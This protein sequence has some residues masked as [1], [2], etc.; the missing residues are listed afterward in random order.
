MPRKKVIP[1]L[2]T[3]IIGAFAA[4]SILIRFT[5]FLLNSRVEKIILFFIAWLV[6]AVI[7]YL[8]YNKISPLYF[9][10][11]IK[12]KKMAI[13]L[14]LI[15]A[16]TLFVFAYKFVYFPQQTSLVIEPVNE[17]TVDDE[18]KEV[19]LLSI[20][21]VD[22][23]T[24]L[25][26]PISLTEVIYDDPWKT[27]PGGL[28][29]SSHEKA[30]GSIRY[31]EFMNDALQLEFST[32]PTKGLVD[33]TW[34]GSTQ[35]I[36][37][38]SSEIGSMLVTLKPSNEWGSADGKRKKWLAMGV[39]SDFVSVLPIIIVVFL[40]GFHTLFSKKIRIRGLRS[41]AVLVILS[42]TILIINNHLQAEIEF[43]DPIL[44]EVVRGKINRPSRSLFRHQL[45]GVVE[46]DLSGQEISS[47]NGIENI[48]NLRSLDL[49]ATG[50][51]DFAP[52]SRL[53]KLEW[54]DLSNS[55]FSD[56]KVIR[57][58]K[59]LVYLDLSQNQISDITPL[60]GLDRLV[61]LMLAN[62]VIHNIDVFYSLNRLQT[63]DLQ[64]NQLSD[65][66][67]VGV[68]A[69]LTDL[70]L[71]GNQISET[72]TI[73]KL[74]QLKY[75]DLSECNIDDA[76]MV[77]NLTGLKTL[78]L[79]GNDIYDVTK[80][81]NLTNLEILN[82]RG[83]K[84]RDIT[85]LGALH[86]LKSLNLRE[87]QISEI[88]A[89][90]RL[91]NLK[92][93]NL[94]SNSSIRDISPLSELKSLEK[95]I[96]RNIP[97]GDQI[98]EIQDLTQ[99]EYLNIRNCSISDFSVIVSLMKRG[100]L[101]D[102]QETGSLATVNL[103]ENAA[104]NFT[105]DPFEG[106]RP[107]W[108]NITFRYPFQLPYI[109]NGI[110]KPELSHDGGFY[111]DSFLLT[112]STSVPQ[113]RIFYTL[114]GE[115]PA[116][117]PHLELSDYTYEY[118]EPITI[119]DQSSQ[120]N[121]L[122]NIEV[123]KTVSYVPPSEVFKATVVRAIVV[124]ENNRRSPL[125]TQTFLVEEG[126]RDH[127]KFPVVSLVTSPKGL[128][129]D[130]VGIYVPGVL[131]KDEN[132]LE[133]AN[134]AN[135]TQRG[136]LWERQASL[137]L[138]SQTG[139]KLIEQDVGVRIH[140]ATHRANPQKFFRIY[141]REIYSGKNGLKFNFF[142]SMN[143]RLNERSVDEYETLILRAG[144]RDVLLQNLFQNTRLDI[145]GAMPV[146][147]LLNGEYWGI[148]YFRP[149]YDANYFKSYYGIENEEL[150]IADWHLIGRNNLD[151]HDQNSITALFT[152]IDENFAKHN[153]ESVN[154]LANPI[155]YN[156]ISAMMDV[157]NY[158]D[159]SFSELYTVNADRHYITWKKSIDPG[160][161]FGDSDYGHDGKWRWLLNDLDQGFK[162]PN[163]NFLEMMTTQE[164]QYTY[165][166]RSLL[167]NQ[168]FKISLINRTADLLNTDFKEIVV[169]E[170]VKIAVEAHEPEIDEQIHRWGTEEGTRESY[171]VT[172]SQV[173][174]F[175]NLRP[176]ILRQQ[177]VQCFK[178]P[179]TGDLTL[180]TDSQFGYI[181]VNTIDIREATA[182]VDN[183]SD[184]TGIYFQGVPIT[185]TAVPAEGYRFSHWEGLESGVNDEAVL[186]LTL[187]GDLELTAVFTQ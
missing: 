161:Q 144:I 93:L 8:F 9:D 122:S 106:L 32:G 54:L 61:I 169:L 28:Q 44:E 121:V 66:E 33:I 99:L 178:L 136:L 43:T 12:T 52:I 70:R 165:L 63:L 42:A 107:Y 90:A 112:L 177:F 125:T 109:E 173:Q 181:R 151:N 150:I 145:Q 68:L 4:F 143:N 47:L 157:S 101:L 53:S 116:V 86:Q 152:V 160:T 159:Y 156:K 149:R 126:I 34:N 65:I 163:R 58:L 139:E 75:L 35:K 183:P 103:L 82:L 140:G 124:D 69:G 179:G 50:I 166:F 131:Y 76:S 123:S 153:Y 174:D 39:L 14:S 127:Y 120:P 48:K 26:T 72:D 5:D 184:W 81:S 128:F 95:L 172:F 135:F 134:V 110:P 130:N 97:V 104:A 71:G 13:F 80:F 10:L 137:Q 138:F 96:L 164:T 24:G 102:D 15:L 20:V 78:N 171:Q 118:T 85:G 16:G 83:N 36:D 187:T 59:K 45:S 147:V 25:K 114:N 40:F 49:S 3:S 29:I 2:F 155:S 133:Y 60:R 168:T 74:T 88:T 117:G 129:D 1:I 111:E 23:S 162:N 146:V 6:F 56:V 18:I 73:R 62:N 176:G 108:Q 19:T 119:K 84:I 186:E 105:I 37:L 11:P 51:T 87:N 79:Q 154:T 94:H 115:F 17:N 141:A 158:I 41:L 46:L 148:Y 167:K 30:I 64:N 185:I 132:I 98:V 182:G 55:G 31:N 142:P 7:I 113:G 67:A 175:A 180:K 57:N 22:F 91:K 89:L 170:K 100:V 27:V 21:R 92:Y 38:G 77:E